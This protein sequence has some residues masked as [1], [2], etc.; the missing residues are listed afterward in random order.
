MAEAEFAQAK[1]RTSHAVLNT[2]ADVREAYYRHVADQQMFEMFRSVVA[3]TEASAGAA[4]KLREAGNITDVELANEQ[5]M[6][7]QAR[8]DLAQNQSNLVE[9]REKLAKLMGLWG[10]QTEW[11]MTSRLPDPSAKGIRLAGLEELALTQRLDLATARQEIAMLAR[12]LGFSRY[13]GLIPQTEVRGHFEREPEGNETFG[14]S[15]EIPIPIFNFGQAG[16]ARAQA[17]VRQ[18]QQRYLALAVEI[19]ADV[20]AARDR[21]LIAQSR[22]AHYRQVMLPLREFAVEKTQLQYNAMQLGPMQ[23]LTAKQEQI[24]AGHDY[25]EAQRDY[26][27]TRTE[28]ERAVGGSFRRDFVPLAS[29]PDQQP[30]AG[31]PH[32]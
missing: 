19:R 12:R 7:E 2:V 25:I 29:V 23:L 9:S 17:K 10:R 21:M 24:R 32:H 30:P 26:W 16:V 14:P 1:L 11:K 6:R 22:V 3:A 15:L 18:A 28:L 20:R 4:E 13:E 31:K 5:A 27:I 8:L